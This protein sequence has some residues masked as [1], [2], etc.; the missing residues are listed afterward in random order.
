M[1]DSIATEVAWIVGSIRALFDE[2]LD[3]SDI[4]WLVCLDDRNAR[5]YFKAISEQLDVL[6]VRVNNLLADPYGEPK[7]HIPKHVTL[8][9]VYRAKGNESAVVF[10][11]GIDAVYPNRKQQQARNKLF[12][13]F[14]RAKGWLRVSEIG[15]GATRFAGEIDKAIQ[16]MPRMQ[17]IQPD[18]SQIMT[19]QRDLSDKEKQAPTPAGADRSAI[20]RLWI[21]TLK[22]VRHSSWD[23]AR[24]NDTT[25][26]HEEPQRPCAHFGI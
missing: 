14:T 24:R 16:S 20:R 15:G 17:F 10:A 22:S 7:F 9:T 18:P 21:S 11:I 23:C 25:G 1:A 13:A 12:T 26:V 2:G 6:D 5:D 8:T 4:I 3:A 19:L